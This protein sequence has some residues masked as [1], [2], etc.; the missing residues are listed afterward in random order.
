M[1]LAIAIAGW[2]VAALL[3]ALCIALCVHDDDARRWTWRLA[4]ER[5]T[6]AKDLSH[7]RDALASYKTACEELQ[8]IRGYSLRRLSEVE[9]ARGKSYRVEVV[10]LDDEN[11][12]CT[13]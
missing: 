9:Q 6:L 4:N 8:R 5:D 2:T 13:G 3:F 1:L 10:N 12:E 7:A 11:T